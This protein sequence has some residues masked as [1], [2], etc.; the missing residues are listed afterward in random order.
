MLETAHIPGSISSCTSGY[1]LYV[2]F[3]ISATILAALHFYQILFA[4]KPKSPV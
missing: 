4:R 3:L 1:A 2:A